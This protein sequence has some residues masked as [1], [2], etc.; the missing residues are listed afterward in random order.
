MNNM[1]E[2]SNITFSPRMEEENRIKGEWQKLLPLI[3]L[4]KIK[5][6]PNSLLGLERDQMLAIMGYSQE[7]IE[8]M[9]GFKWADYPLPAYEATE[10]DKL[11]SCGREIYDKIKALEIKAD[12][13]WQAEHDRLLESG[14]ARGMI[15]EEQNYS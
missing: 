6:R 8:E 10:E 12:L 5:A 2:P 1:T 11:R 3:D 7:Q 13:E 9:T 4:L 14:M 15:E